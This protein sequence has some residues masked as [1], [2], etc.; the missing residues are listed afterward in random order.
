MYMDMEWL[1]R[2]LDVIRSGVADKL[3]EGNVTV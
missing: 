1:Q 3:S 2:A